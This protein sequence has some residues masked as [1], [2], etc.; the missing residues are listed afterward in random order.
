VGRLIVERGFSRFPVYEDSIDNILGL[1]HVKDALSTLE[2]GE[3]LVVRGILHRAHFVPENKK[4]G[5]LLKELQRRRT[6]MAVVVDEHGSVSGLVTLEDI[7]E[8]IVGEIHDE[9][10]W[11]ERPV[12]QL[13]DGSLVVEGTVSASEL[14]E[15][16]GIPLPESTE[17]ETV[18]GFMLDRLGSVPKGGEVVRL[19]EWR[20]TVVDVEGNRVSKVKAEQLAA[21]RASGG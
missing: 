5:P 13:R 19:G 11:E 14:R 9:H 17:F 1:L 3:P 8:E 20:L 10:D 21:P 15:D 4:V 18:A 2:K 12:E 16:Y 6:H 7:L